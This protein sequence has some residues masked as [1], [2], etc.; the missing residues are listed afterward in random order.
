MR[1]ELWNFY[2]IFFHGYSYPFWCL[3]M[4]SS[5]AFLYQLTVLISKWRVY[6]SHQMRVS[7]HFLLFSFYLVL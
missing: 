3:A 6:T 1:K 2:L 4:A 5:S 7:G